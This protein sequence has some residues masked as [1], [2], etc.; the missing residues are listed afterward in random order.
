MLRTFF[1]YCFI[2]KTT[3][4]RLDYFDTIKMHQAEQ[5][6][7]N[8]VITLRIDTQKKNQIDELRVYFFEIL[9]EKQHNKIYNSVYQE[10]DLIIIECQNFFSAFYNSNLQICD[11]YFSK[12]LNLFRRKCNLF[13][14]QVSHYKNI[15]Q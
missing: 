10:Y 3:L 13:E 7:K 12:T 11:Q 15:S 8:N 2:F 1:G 6:V 9:F 14:R 4:L 5:N